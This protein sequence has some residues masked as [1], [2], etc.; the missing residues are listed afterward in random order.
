MAKNKITASFRLFSF[1]TVLLSAV[2]S[3]VLHIVYITAASD[4]TVSDTLALVAKYSAT[5]FSL[6]SICAAVSSTVYAHSYF[7]KKTALN[8]SLISVACL[9][10]GKV[11]MFVYNLLA[12][13]LS[14]AQ[15]I[16]GAIS[17]L[18]EVMFDCLIV[19]LALII[20]MT[21]A[22]KRDLSN[23]ENAE[24]KYSPLRASFL[25]LAAYTL[26]LI[27][28]LTVM[29]VIPFLVKYDNFS[30]IEIKNIVSDYLYYLFHLPVFFLLSLLFSPYL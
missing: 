20:S 1:L 28:D 16:S 13:E 19:S 10:F 2:L 25:S 18:T 26:L 30:A 6:F 5:L 23:K 29:N 14:S 27:A 17:Y 9:F 12:N 3:K 11:G 4:I 7:G 24:A 15:I 8:I 22:K 21:F